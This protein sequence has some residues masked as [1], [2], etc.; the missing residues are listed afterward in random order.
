TKEHLG[1]S[2]KTIIALRKMLLKA[3]NDLAEGKDPP[4]II[5]ESNNADFSRLRS[6]KGVLRAGRDWREI[7]EGLGPNDG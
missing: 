6:V 1:Y 3:V 5:R 7:M 2:D 4:H